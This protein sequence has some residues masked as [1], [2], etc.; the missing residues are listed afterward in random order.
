[1]GET[2]KHAGEMLKSYCLA[3]GAGNKYSSIEE[4]FSQM[5]T[6]ARASKH[7]L[8]KEL[9]S[10]SRNLLLLK[11]LNKALVTCSLRI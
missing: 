7:W 5:E 10:L 4:L 8:A 1:M 2:G 9:E 11:L 3:K 6:E